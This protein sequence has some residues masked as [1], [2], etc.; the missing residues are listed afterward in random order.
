MRMPRALRLFTYAF[1]EED[2]EKFERLESLLTRMK[3]YESYFRA[4]PEAFIQITFRIISWSDKVEF[5]AE[6]IKQARKFKFLEKVACN[7]NFVSLLDHW[8]TACIIL[9]IFTLAESHMYGVLI[10]YYRMFRYDPTPNAWKTEHI[11]F[12]WKLALFFFTY[13]SISKWQ[14]NISFS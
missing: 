11:R 12:K 14:R 13:L 7:M 1:E 10:N 2:A 6:G 3:Q 9:C 8:T 4:A 5:H